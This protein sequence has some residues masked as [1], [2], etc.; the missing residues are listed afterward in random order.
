VTAKAR[1]RST[2]RSAST[3]PQSTKQVARILP[4]PKRRASIQAAVAVAFEGE[5][6]RV[7]FGEDDEAMATLGKNVDRAVVETSVARGETLIVQESPNGL[8]VLGALRTA[9]T[10]GVDKGDEFVIEANRIKMVGAH[11]VSI[12]S[13]AAQLAVRAVGMVETIANDI[14]TRAAGVHKLIGRM[15]HLN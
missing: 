10:P 1:K 14:T 15:L 4:L 7:R 8:L 6:V 9:A 3:G 5:R 13:G 2:Q 11:Q 12:V